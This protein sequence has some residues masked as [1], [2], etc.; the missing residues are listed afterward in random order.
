MSRSTRTRAVSRSPSV[1]NPRH[2]AAAGSLGAVHL[3]ADQDPPHPFDEQRVPTVLYKYFVPYLVRLLQRIALQRLIG[4]ARLALVAEGDR[5]DGARPAPQGTGQPACL[6]TLNEQSLAFTVNGCLTEIS[7]RESISQYYE[8]VQGGLR[9]QDSFGTIQRALRDAEGMDNDRFQGSAL[10]ELRVL[11]G[12]LKRLLDE[13][14][15]NARLVADVQSKVAWL[16]VFFVSYYFTA[17]MQYVSHGDVFKH[18]FT[19]CSLILAPRSPAPPRFSS[20][21]RT[22]CTRTARTPHRRAR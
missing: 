22:S 6:R 12:D 13:A 17:L 14:G 10:D 11:A 19:M 5:T 1:L 4:E 8:L 20:S 16:E 18:E 15:Y 3:V 2:W 7:S 21:S 9:V